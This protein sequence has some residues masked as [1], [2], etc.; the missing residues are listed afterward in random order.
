LK[1]QGLVHGSFSDYPLLAAK[2][3]STETG[4]ALHNLSLTWSYIDAFLNQSF[5]QVKSPLL[6]IGTD[7][8]EAIVKQ[9]GH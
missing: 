7:H 8:P 9:Y 4:D 6:E 5:N 3:R 1:S 2:G